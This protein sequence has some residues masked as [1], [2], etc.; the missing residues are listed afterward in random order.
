MR[1]F[2]SANKRNKLTFIAE[3]L[4][5]GLA[6]KLENGKVNINWDNR[7][8]RSACPCVIYLRLLLTSF[9][10]I[11]F[12]W[13]GFFRQSMI[14]IYCRPDQSGRL[15]ALQPMEQIFSWMIPSQVR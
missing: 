2:Q 13:A 7:K 14:G 6:E 11:V 5:D 9:A 1:L 4:D 10:M 3:P 15:E 8:V 12:S